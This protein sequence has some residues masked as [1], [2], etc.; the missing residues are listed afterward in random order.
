VIATTG[1]EFSDFAPYVASVNNAGMVAFQAALQESGTG[2]FIAD[3]EHVEA[4]AGGHR[5]TVSSHPDLNDDGATS[6]YASEGVYRVRDGRLETV[7]D[8]NGPFTSIGPLGPTM[9]TAGTVAFRADLAGGVSGIF[10][11]DATLAD[12]GGPFAKFHGLPVIDAS[13]TV[14]FRADRT[15]G[16]EGV[17]AA[18]DGEVEPIVETGVR[19]ESLAPFPSA[20][21]AGTVAFASGAGVFTVT[22]GKVVRIDEEGTFESCRGALIDNAGAVVVIA[23]P[24]G[25]TLGLYSGNERILGIGDALFGSTVEDFASNPVSLNDRGRLAVRVKLTDGAQHIIL[26]SCW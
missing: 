26:A 2:V 16:V 6:F 17:Y 8:T 19:F 25:G 13:G 21:D 14:V 5:L 15:D 24:P 22:G 11:G 18:G 1:A 7:A 20:N 3:G 10:A 9:N 23:T 4:V 12:T